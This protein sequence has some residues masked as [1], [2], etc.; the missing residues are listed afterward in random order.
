MKNN[1]WLAAVLLLS[2]LAA[3]SAQ[4]QGT[5]RRHIIYFKDKAGTPYSVSQP[6]AF[7]SAR[8]LTRRSRQGIV[9]R[10]RDLPVSPTYVAQIRAVSGSP[11]L[12]YTSRWLNAAVVACDSATLARIYQLPAV[13]SGQTLSILPQSPRAAPAPLPAIGVRAAADARATYGGRLPG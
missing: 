7:L 8:A 10:T 3:T 4:A 13:K 2:L 6:Q 11:Q 12:V 5:V 9:V 1:L